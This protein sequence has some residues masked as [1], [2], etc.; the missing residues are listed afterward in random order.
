MTFLVFIFY[1][2]FRL[3]SGIVLG[4]DEWLGMSEL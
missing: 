1:E 2:I 4:K 3:K